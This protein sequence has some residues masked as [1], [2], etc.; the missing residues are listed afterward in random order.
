MVWLDQFKVSAKAQ[1]FVSLAI[2]ELA[3]NWIKYGCLDRR[4]YHMRFDLSLRN[5]KL[6]LKAVDDGLAF[7]PLSVPAP[8]TSIPLEERNLGGLGIL[9][10]RKMADQISY[11]H[12]D[13]MNILQL[14]KASQ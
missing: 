4:E 11:E 7:N 10:L 3:T 5:E 14:E 2:E 1:Y 8:S 9:L 12:R 13:G 6:I